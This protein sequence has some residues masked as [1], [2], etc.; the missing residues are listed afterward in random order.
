MDPSNVDKIFESATICYCQLL[1][2]DLCSRLLDSIYF[3]WV[4]IKFGNSIGTFIFY[5]SSR[6]CEIIIFY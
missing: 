2:E 3:V 4:A 5:H 1:G 6:K